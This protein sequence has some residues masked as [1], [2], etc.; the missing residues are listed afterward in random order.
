MMI[1]LQL[2]QLSIVG[3]AHGTQSPKFRALFLK[4]S[5]HPHL[6]A[7]LHSEIL[8]SDCQIQTQLI[9]VRQ[10]ATIYQAHHQSAI[11][12]ISDQ[13]VRS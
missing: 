7:R 12:Y 11:Y 1:F 13:Q 2:L 3:L 4:K 10:I 6:C 9:R 5:S 8:A